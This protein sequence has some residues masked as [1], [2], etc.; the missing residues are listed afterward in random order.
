M[1]FGCFIFHRE[2]WNLILASYQTQNSNPHDLRLKCGRTTGAVYNSVEESLWTQPR[3]PFLKYKVQ[4]TEGNT[5]LPAE[6]P[7]GLSGPWCQGRHLHLLPSPDLQ[8]GQ[9]GLWDSGQTRGRWLLPPCLQSQ[10]GD[11]L[12]LPTDRKRVWDRET[13]WFNLES[14]FQETSN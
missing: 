7:S 4:T 14:P 1:G 12:H 9:S 6:A 5:S 11:C 3:E 8:A 2:K 10:V 13:H